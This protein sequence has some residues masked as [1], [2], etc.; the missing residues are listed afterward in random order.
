[1]IPVYASSKEPFSRITKVVSII[2]G[3]PGSGKS[4]LINQ[5]RNKTEAN[6][7]GKIFTDGTQKSESWGDYIDTPGLLSGNDVQSATSIGLK[8]LLWK[9]NAID[10]R[11]VLVLPSHTTRITK[12]WGNYIKLNGALCGP[13]AP[14]NVVLTFSDQIDNTN[15]IREELKQQCPGGRIKYDNDVIQAGHLNM[16]PHQRIPAKPTDTLGA[17]SQTESKPTKYRMRATITPASS[18]KISVGLRSQIQDM[19]NLRRRNDSDRFDALEA[20]GG[21]GLLLRVVVDAFTRDNMDVEAVAEQLLATNGPLTSIFDK[22]CPEI[23]CD[24]HTKHTIMK[25]TAGN[26]LV[27]KNTTLDEICAMIVRPRPVPP[28]V[29]P[30]LAASAASAPTAGTSISSPLSSHAWGELAT[31]S[32]RGFFEHYVNEQAAPCKVHS[33]WIMAEINTVI[34][35]EPDTLFAQSAGS[36]AKH[37]DVVDYSDVDTFVWC[38]DNIPAKRRRKL[39]HDIKIRLQAKCKKKIQIEF[40]TNATAYTIFPDGEK[41]LSV[42]IVF[43]KADWGERCLPPDKNSRFHN[44]PTLQRAVR[45]LKLLSRNVCTVTLKKPKKSLS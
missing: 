17:R 22:A 21:Y 36:T 43:E 23:E 28:I 9:H 42:D 26:A 27:H 25:A 19:D 3:P 1:M 7:S 18:N 8:E 4:T 12:W 11:L 14:V 24:N 33:G 2:V 6:V 34:H 44:C 5:L 38:S 39:C 45:A 32:L 20:M 31:S 10:F 37:I 15:K 13:N 41:K 30:G 16:F 29:T 35:K 40:K